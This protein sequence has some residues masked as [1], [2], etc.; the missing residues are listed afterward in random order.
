MTGIVRPRHE[1]EQARYR[2]IGDVTL[3]P[4]DDV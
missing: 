2:R 3:A 4:V 1:R